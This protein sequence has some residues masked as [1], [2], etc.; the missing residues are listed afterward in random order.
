MKHAKI[1][2][3]LNAVP[4]HRLKPLISEHADLDITAQMDR[5]RA[6]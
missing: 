1:D 3:N 4:M 2:Y 6:T 5:H